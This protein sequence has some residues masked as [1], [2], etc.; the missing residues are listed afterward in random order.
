MAILELYKKNPKHEK[1]KL[2]IRFA[3]N[4]NTKRYDTGLMLSESEWE[5]EKKKGYP[6]TKSAV[7]DESKANKLL[8]DPDLSP[9]LRC[10]SSGIE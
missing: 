7:D 2:V 4:R 6:K 9:G 3:V 1:H 5:I 8:E 10:M